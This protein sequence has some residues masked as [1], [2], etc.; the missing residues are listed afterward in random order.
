VN[1]EEVFSA[2]AEDMLNQFKKMAG[3]HRHRGLRGAYREDIVRDFLRDYL[4]SH[5]E[6]AGGEIFDVSGA[7][8]PE[9][10]AIVFDRIKVPLMFSRSRRF[11]PIEGVYSVVEVKSNLDSAELADCLKKCLVVKGLQK[12]AYIRQVG[13]IEHT[14][15][16]YGTAHPYFPT[17]FSIFAY[18]SINPDTI[19]EAIKVFQDEHPGMY[20]DGAISLDGWVAVWR[21]PQTRE[22]D[23]R[24]SP[25][26]ELVILESETNA[27]LTFYLMY[28]RWISQAWCDPIH[29]AAYAARVPLGRVRGDHI[30]YG[31]PISQDDAD[32]CPPS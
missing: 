23:L 6:I 2:I 18:T 32:K 15:T 11:L 5:V 9:C 29:M 28:Y 14:F 3:Q 31:Y 4:P 26:S 25:G 16:V 20:L 30:I 21:N 10:E 8:S 1:F 17:M 22:V 27:L 24:F 13:V 12:T 7:I 19:L